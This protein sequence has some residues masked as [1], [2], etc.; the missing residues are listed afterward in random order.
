MRSTVRRDSIILIAAVLM[1][2]VYIA[3]AG[4][5]FPLDDSWIHQT[6]G[7]NLAQYGEWAFLPGVAS[8]IE[9]FSIPPG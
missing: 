3:A 1:A 5:G 7:R 2:A 6:Y 8:A 9:V 4:G